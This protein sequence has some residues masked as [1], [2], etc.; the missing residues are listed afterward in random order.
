[1]VGTDWKPWHP[2]P[3]DCPFL[4]ISEKSLNA[5]SAL[6]K[7]APSQS[8]EAETVDCADHVVVT[9]GDVVFRRPHGET[10]IDFLIDHL[11]YTYG[12][13]WANEQYAIDADERH[14]VMRWWF[15]FCELQ[16]AA[17]GPNHG[18]GDVYALQP[19]GD[20]MEYVSLADDLCRLRLVDALRPK[21]VDRLRHH[22]EFQGARYECAIAASFVRCGFEIVW[23]AGPETK[24]EFIGTQKLTGESVAVEVKSRRRPGTLNEGGTMPDASSLCLDVQRLYD[25]ALTQCPSDVPCAIFI[26]VNLP[27]QVAGE[28][29]AIPWW[30]DIK[31]ML[32]EYPEPTADAPALETCLVLTNFN[33]YSTGKSSATA[34]PYDLLFPR[35]VRTR[36]TNVNTFIAIMRAIDTYGHTPEWEH[37]HNT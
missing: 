9:V 11:K 18:K 36:L 8:P 16:K 21:M 27:P 31:R 37:Q 12:K 23:Q 30:D 13:K 14:V 4:S 3:D 5:C 29:G 35:F 7:T 10:Q 28:V 17:A 2:F 6:M 33:W 15:S 22:A 32:S 25:K 26:D 1:M 24:C 19:S 20:A 34:H